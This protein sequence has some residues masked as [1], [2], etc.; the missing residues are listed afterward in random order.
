LGAARQSEPFELAIIGGGVNGCGI[1]R[2]AAG[3]GASVVLFEQDD[4]A[5]GTSSRSTKLI[6]GGLRY[7][8]Y[9]EFRLVQDALRERDVL[10]RLAPHI[11]EPARFVL[12]HHSGMRSRWLLRLGLFLYDHIGGR[13]QLPGTSTLDLTRDVAGAALKPAYRHAFEYSDCRVDD[14]RL[15]VLNARDAAERGAVIR[16][17][18]RVTN[19]SRQDD[20][21]R[22]DVEG[23][24]GRETIEARVLVNAA[25]PWVG[26]VASTVIGADIAAPVRL[27]QGSHILVPRLFAHEKCYIFQNADGRIVFALPFWQDFT[28][29]GTT[30][31]DYRG[32]PSAVTASSDEIAYLCA[33]ASEYFRAPVRSEDVVWSYSGV[34]P[35]QDDGSTKAQEAT[36]DYTLTLDAG[37]GRAALLTIL[38]GKI[39]TYRVLAELAVNELKGHLAAASQPNWTG[40]VALPGGDFAPDGLP[41][42]IDATVRAHPYLD[43][44]LAERL[45]RAY[46]TR[47]TK[48]LGGAHAMSDLGADFGA[49]LTEREIDYLMQEEWAQRADDVLWRRSK[50]GLRL[51]AAQTAA[52]EDVM[53]RKADTAPS[54]GERR[55][56]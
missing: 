51:S 19:A 49:G 48:L 36:R 24:D 39:T 47:V 3:R 27:V 25:G 29:I 5:G 22:V 44:A 38:G 54:Q 10:W 32:D 55:R 11:V 46:G 35:L 21:W 17:R 13:R 6:H 33:A 15:V 45:V 40:R 2:D 31:L 43:R 18:T 7:L 8:E 12:P 9:Y 30:D 23:R 52:L 41:A 56:A 42:L 28:L 53:R 16:P 34:R 1:A 50:L 14:A 20:H 26:E 37:P 4:L